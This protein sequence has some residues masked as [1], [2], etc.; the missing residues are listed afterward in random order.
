[1]DGFSYNNIF[2]TKGIEYIIIIAFLLMIIPFWVMINRQISLKSQIRNAIGILSE[3]ILR[4]PKGLLF[5]RN[6]TW[7]HLG[8]SGVAEVGI[9]DFLLHVTGEVRI[10]GLKEPGSFIKKG[11]LLAGI[12]HNGKILKVYSPISGRVEKINSLLTDD[13]SA[14]NGDPY[15][16]GW[17]CKINPARWTEETGSYYLA[18]EALAW[19]KAELQRFKD[20]LAGSVRKYSPEAS[21]VILQDGGELYDRPLSDLPDEIWHDFQKSFLDVSG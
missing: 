19:T 10:G 9:D 6:H 3:S 2:E 4:I 5:N 14:I 12:D 16:K 1:M 21:L 7:V 11:D 20:F 18:D 15:E 17:I 8:K 13:P